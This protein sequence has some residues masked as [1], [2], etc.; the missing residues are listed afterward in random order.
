MKRIKLTQG[1]YAFVDDEDFYILNNIKWWAHK[2]KNTFYAEAWINN[3]KIKMHKFLINAPRE[4]V[5]DHKDG[6]GLNNCKSNLRVATKTQNKGN[7]NIRKDN[8]IGFKGVR[9][10][11]NKYSPYVYAN[12]KDIYLGCFNTKEEAA[13][14]YDK[15]AIEYHG[16]FARTNKMMG[17]L[18]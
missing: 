15:A 2:D 1:K 11:G 18:N 5:I 4:Y 8:K 12:G 6:N 17:L 10:A 7:R 3:K 9:R 14:A 16:E 13:K